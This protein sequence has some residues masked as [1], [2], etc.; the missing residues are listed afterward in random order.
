MM[1]DDF[2]KKAIILLAAEIFAFKSQNVS[3]TTWICFL[4]QFASK[5]PFSGVSLQNKTSIL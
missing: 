1:I 3:L 2:K 4:D 5:Q